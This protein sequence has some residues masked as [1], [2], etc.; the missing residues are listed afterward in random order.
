ML[1]KFDDER[2][3]EVIR[4]VVARIGKRDVSAD[5]KDFVK[6]GRGKG[7]GVSGVVVFVIVFLVLLVINSGEGEF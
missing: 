7:Y 2:R 5:V 6:V 1:T 4:A 3:L